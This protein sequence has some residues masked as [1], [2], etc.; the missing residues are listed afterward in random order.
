MIWY[1]LCGRNKVIQ[2]GRRDLAAPAGDLI[3][4]PTISHNNTRP[5]GN[6]AASNMKSLWISIAFSPLLSW[7]HSG[8]IFILTSCHLSWPENHDTETEMLN[9]FLLASHL[10]QNIHNRHP[11]YPSEFSELIL[12]SFQRP[13]C[14]VVLLFPISCYILNRIITVCIGCTKV[15]RYFNIYVNLP[16]YLARSRSSMNYPKFNLE[17]TWVAPISP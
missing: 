10:T 6:P 11:A 5:T 9:S 4:F 7:V 8:Q 14:D 3:G 17:C 13:K 15:D 2:N 12:Q 1:N 16:W